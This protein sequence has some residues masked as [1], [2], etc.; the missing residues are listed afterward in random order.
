MATRLSPYRMTVADLRAAL[1]DLPDWAPVQVATY[2]D[3]GCVTDADPYIAYDHGV[4]TI[5]TANAA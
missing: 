5:D 3:D 4:L 1:A 2:D